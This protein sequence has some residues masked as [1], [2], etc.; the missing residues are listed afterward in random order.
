MDREDDAGRQ[1]ILEQVK[2]EMRRRNLD[3]TL[4][5]FKWNDQENKPL[6]LN[7]HRGRNQEALMFRR[8]D[9]E[10]WPLKPGLY[11]KYSGRML[12]AINKLLQEKP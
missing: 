9:V 5:V 12:E 7:V 10:D 8:A 1:L 4:L 2:G 11:A 3:P 6:V